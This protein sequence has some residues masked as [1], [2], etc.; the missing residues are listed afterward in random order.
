MLMTE[1]TS[2]LMFGVTMILPSVDIHGACGWAGLVPG[3]DRLI[4]LISFVAPGVNT[5]IWFPPLITTSTLS[6][7]TSVMT[8]DGSGPTGWVRMSLPVSWSHTSRRLLHHS[9]W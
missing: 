3:G 2:R 1:A 6:E 4:V 5:M 7:P 8:C 9:V